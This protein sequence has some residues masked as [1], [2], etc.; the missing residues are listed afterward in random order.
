MGDFYNDIPS[1]YLQFGDQIGIT[2][3]SLER[4]H[5]VFFDVDDKRELASAILKANKK[6]DCGAPPR[7]SIKIV[8]A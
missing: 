7:F 2:I 5:L 4:L 8:I 1:C 3:T 6:F